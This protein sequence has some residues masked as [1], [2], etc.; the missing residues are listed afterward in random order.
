MNKQSMNELWAHV[1]SIAMMDA[2]AYDDSDNY[3]YRLRRGDD[4]HGITVLSWDGASEW[5]VVKYDNEEAWE[6]GDYT[7]ATETTAKRAPYDF[8]H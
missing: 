4:N 5:M 8:N 7:S 2:S 1:A 3:F 6:Y